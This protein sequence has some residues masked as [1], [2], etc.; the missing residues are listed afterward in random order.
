MNK[1]LVVPCLALMLVAVVAAGCGGKSKSKAYAY[2]AMSLPAYRAALNKICGQFE[3][4]KSAFQTNSLSEVAATGGKLKTLV[5]HELDQINKLQ[6]PAQVKS[7]VDDSVANT[8]QQLKLLDNLISAAKAG[9]TAKAQ[10]IAVQIKALGQKNQQDAK[11]IG[12][13]TCETSG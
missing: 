9:D 3:T 2:G 6:A 12:A 5:Q 4:A 13:T 7:A 10:Q 8:Q 11:K 1:L